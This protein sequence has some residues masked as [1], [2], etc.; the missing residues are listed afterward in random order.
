MPSL[1][2]TALWRKTKKGVVCSIYSHMKQRNK[3]DFSLEYL[4]EFSLCKK[5]QRLY[6]EWVKSG[7]NKDSKP[8]IDRI[9]RKRHY[10]FGNIQWLSWKD[11][12]FKQSMERRHTRSHPVA[13]ILNGKIV[14]TFKSQL[15]AI[16]KTGVDQRNLTAVLNGRRNVCS[17][18]N[19]KYIK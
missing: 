18:Y 5:F 8:T 2:S 3:V 15:D 12:R 16:K 7:Y 4:I 14:N 11:N 13:Q 1:E 6:N 10:T 9:N 19:W 17:G